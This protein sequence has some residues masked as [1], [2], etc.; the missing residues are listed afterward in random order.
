NPKEIT[1]KGGLLSNANTQ[2]DIN[3][4][5]RVFIGDRTTDLG[6]KLK[7]NEITNP[8]KAEVIQLLNDFLESFKTI[9]EKINYADKFGLYKIDHDNLQRII[10]NDALEAI[11]LGIIRQMESEVQNSDVVETLFFYPLIKGVNKYAFELS[12]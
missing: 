9:D 5:K 6:I 1:C 10:L 12:T 2:S 11:N 8:H 3:I 4:I 7:Y